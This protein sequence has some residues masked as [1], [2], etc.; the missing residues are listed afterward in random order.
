LIFSLSILLAL[1]LAFAASDNALVVLDISSAFFNFLDEFL[2][3][4]ACSSAIFVKLIFNSSKT[5]I[6]ALPSLIKGLRRSFS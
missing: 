3:I 6:K 1:S 4:L 2:A 5:L